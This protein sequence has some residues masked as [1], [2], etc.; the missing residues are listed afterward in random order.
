MRYYNYR[1]DELK[2]NYHGTRIHSDPQILA[3]VKALLNRL[4]IPPSNW[5]KY[6]NLTLYELLLKLNREEHPQIS[7]ILKL[8]DNKTAI[9]K[10]TLFI[11][12]GTF[13]FFVASILSAPVFAP[14]LS[15]L[16]I[17]LTSA[18][19]LPVLGLAYTVISSAVIFYQNQVDAKRTLLNRIHDNFILLVKSSLNI[20]GYIFW[21][22]AATPMTP[23]VAGLFVA[24]SAVDV[25][26]EITDL[27][28]SY[29]KHK[30]RPSI[31][32]SS[33]L[34]IHQTYARNEYGFRK[35]RNALII[36][37]ITSILL[38][39]IM[40]AWC[41]LPPALI[42]TVGSVVAI[43]V[44]FGIKCL[45]HKFNE[46]R[47]REQL[48]I[49]LSKIEQDYRTT[50][51]NDALDVSPALSLLTSSA[52][53]NDEGNIIQT[54]E[55]QLERKGSLGPFRRPV[56]EYQPHYSNNQIQLW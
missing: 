38:L 47:V 26:K 48:Q 4:N 1:L 23:L 29:S 7:Y 34:L 17:L 37:L 35:H 50:D 15:A 46:A 24:A 31:H 10:L 12:G 32:E 18:R 44:V 22:I 56:E 45:L 40:A 25:I 5:E 30:N 42:L 55:V 28:Q 13:I 2:T 51:N 20:T 43:G 41:F 33:Q 9:R 16:G 52:P 49:E 53:S 11:Y 3:K 39:G 19:G 27:T 21:M 54:P 14:V 36:N 6:L 8:I